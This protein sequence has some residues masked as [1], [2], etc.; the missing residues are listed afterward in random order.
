MARY[1][2][3]CEGC[4]EYFEY[5]SS[6]EDRNTPAPCP[7]CEGLAPRIFVMP[8]M[9]RIGGDGSDRQIKAMKHSFR[10]RF[11]QKEMD[12]VRHKHGNNFDESLASAAVERI[13][14]KQEDEI[15]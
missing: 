5:D 1:D 9:I 11:V 12:D 3:Y 2:Y 15:L 7:D 4:D 8:P 6:M 14:N 13:K 10:K